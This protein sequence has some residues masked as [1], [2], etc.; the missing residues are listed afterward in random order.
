MNALDDFRSTSYLRH[1]ARRLEH[2]ASLNLDIAGKTVLELGAGIG[3]HTTFYLDR[4]C[5]VTC[6]EAR[7]KNWILMVKS[8][9][10]DSRSRLVR[11][12]VLDF[13]TT[14]TFDIVHCYG[15]LY[16]TEEPQAVLEKAAH[17]CRGMLL[18]ETC[19]SF[20]DDQA[21]NPVRERSSGPSQS[22]TGIGCRPT[23]PWIWARLKELF[24]FV[25]APKTQ[26]AHEDFPLD[27]TVAPPPG[28]D[29]R[30]VF[31]ASRHEIDNPM[32]VDRLPMQQAAQ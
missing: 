29:T 15:L 3:D 30:A 13:E 10:T 16:H 24:P 32:L 9:P 7:E 17:Y 8:S 26:P 23:R 6:L 20:G 2:L 18:L 11:M 31:I 28:R 5:S 4:A 22:L 14:E 12:D 19:V 25:H 21:I 1:N 27:W